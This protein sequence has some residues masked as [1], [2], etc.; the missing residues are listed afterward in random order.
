MYT[1]DH[2]YTHMYTKY[3]RQKRLGKRLSGRALAWHVRGPDSIPSA[4]GKEA[5]DIFQCFY[6][7]GAQLNIKL[8]S[9]IN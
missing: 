8:R 9:Y 2:T 1:V 6:I 5:V 4:A 3:K 7:E